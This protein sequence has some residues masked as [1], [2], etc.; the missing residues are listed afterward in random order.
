MSISRKD[1]SAVEP[2]LKQ[3]WLVTLV[4]ESEA[5]IIEA[6]QWAWAK[7]NFLQEIDVLKMSVLNGIA[8]DTFDNTNKCTV[9]NTMFT[10]DQSFHTPLSTSQL[11]NSCII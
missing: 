5:M 8:V 7:L 4:E 11:G 3:H 1:L 10:L 6:N 9:Y 2:I